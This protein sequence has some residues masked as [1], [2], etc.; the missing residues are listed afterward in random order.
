MSASV[1]REQR[2]SRTL[3]ICRSIYTR[4]RPLSAQKKPLNLYQTEKISFDLYIIPI[5]TADLFYSILNPVPVKVS[6]L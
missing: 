2:P 4:K 6:E 3:S 1:L 5:S